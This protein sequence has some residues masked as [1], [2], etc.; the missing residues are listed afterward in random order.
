MCRLSLSPRTNCLLRFLIVTAI[1][2][3]TG[4]KAVAA[5]APANLDF[6]EGEVGKVPVGWTV[7]ASADVKG[8][9]ALI[10]EDNPK[11][12]KRCVLL[13]RDA[14]G[15]NAVDFYASVAQGKLTQAL[16][17]APFRGKRVAFKVAARCEPEKNSLA[18]AQ[19]LVRISPKAGAPNFFDDMADR[20]IVQKEWR[21]CQIVAEVAE[22]SD[23]ID[24]ELILKGN[25]KA[26]FDH[27]RIE[28]IGKAGEGNEPA[29]A[30]DD[31]GLDNLV[32]FARLLGYVR[33][34]HPADEAAAT[35]WNAFAHGGVKAVEKAKNPQELVAVLEKLIRR[36]APPLR[37][38][39]TGAIHDDLPSLAPPAGKD[40]LKIVY[41]RH[42]GVGT[43]SPGSIYS[44]E[45]V[46]SKDPAKSLRKGDKLPDAAPPDP[47]KPFTADL[48]GGVSCWLPLSLYGDDTGTYPRIA[49]PPAG[50][51]IKA[52]DDGSANIFFT[53][54]D[55]ATRLAAVA[56]AWNVFQH[57]YPYFDAVQTDWPAELRKALKAAATDPNERAFLDTLRRLVAALHDGH[58]RVN[59]G[60]FRYQET[61]RPPFQWDWV[62][63][64]LAIVHAPADADLKPGD[65]VTKIEGRPA[66]EV[67]AQR[68][69]LISSATPQ[70]RRYV[71][72]AELA[73]G[74]K[75]S[76]LK[77]EILSPAGQTREVKLRRTVPFTEFQEK[78][79]E[80]IAE[81]KPGVMYVDIDRITDAEFRAARP[82]LA[83]ATGIVFDLRGY[84]RRGGFGVLDHLTD[85][86]VNCAQWHIP[87]VL[88]PDHE[89]MQFAFSDWKV[90]PAQPRFKAKV[91][92]LS[93]G[94]AISAAETI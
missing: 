74:V 44:S 55:R 45:R 18:G 31:R 13:S 4:P 82:K 2:A 59:Q 11:S 16:D 68:E 47:A 53:G 77:L 10:S 30:L 89:K 26:W 8:F 72:L 19:F 27:V 50:V 7:P 6:E 39:L 12:G 88:R 46:N 28:V 92:F 9:T 25:G 73:L 22:D 48:G 43:G 34:F 41:W 56:L 65:V 71:A 36:I 5:Q 84:P 76:A 3:A 29:R 52:A 49:L 78:R 64:R 14:K 87:F 32:A 54:N 33:Y 63:E 23:R 75:D 24:L 1:F 86:P 40:N 66:P 51:V 79:P 35:D 57:F 60:G 62:E 69:E 85:K 58:G 61:F 21:D 42:Y 70:Y 67:I 83:E 37:V 80:K 38:R 20:P 94:R 15:K 90:K 91:A 17:A 93:D 81:L